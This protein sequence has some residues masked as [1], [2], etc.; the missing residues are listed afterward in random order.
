M[1]TDTMRTFCLKDIPLR[2]CVDCDDRRARVEWKV[3]SVRRHSAID[4]GSD[5]IT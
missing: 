5:M 3:D 2:V 4:T 1:D